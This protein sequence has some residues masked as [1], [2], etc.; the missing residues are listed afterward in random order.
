MFSAL[1]KNFFFWFPSARPF[2]STGTKH[3]VC[4]TCDFWPL[5]VIYRSGAA[6]SCGFPFFASAR[7]SISA[8]LSWRETKKAS[9]TTALRHAEGEG[10]GGRYTYWNCIIFSRNT[11]TLMNDVLKI[12]CDI[13]EMPK[14]N[15]PQLGAFSWKFSELRSSWILKGA[16]TWLLDGH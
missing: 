1:G 12:F 4:L 2:V 13:N 9:L 7:P 16:N 15:F 6:F 10:V 3:E 14:T 8:T 11:S 5:L